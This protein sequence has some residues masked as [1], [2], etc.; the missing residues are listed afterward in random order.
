MTLLKWTEPRA[1]ARITYKETTYSSKWSRPV[2]A[3]FA[4]VGML[5]IWGIAKLNPHKNAPPFW[6][7]CILAAI[8]GV[9]ITYIVPWMYSFVSAQFRITEK[10][11][12]RIHGNTAR[13]VKPESVLSFD[14]E[15]MYHHRIIRFRIKKQRDMVSAIPENVSVIDVERCLLALKI[16]RWER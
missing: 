13:T 5:A 15:E 10:S 12:V 1:F 11:I 6:A 4:G 2:W 7:A 16:K 8:F 3:F 14:F 9:F